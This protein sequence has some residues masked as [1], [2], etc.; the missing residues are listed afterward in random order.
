MNIENTNNKMQ[1]EFK[2]R[3]I[4]IT[5]FKKKHRQ[6][7][8]GKQTKKKNCEKVFGENFLC[9]FTV[10]HI[11]IQ[12]WIEWILGTFGSG[13]PEPELSRHRPKANSYCTSNCYD[14]NMEPE[15]KAPVID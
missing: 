8:T 9:I 14:A 13:V 10:L 7:N 12:A 1:I 6:S 11:I 5:E 3:L 15:S 4:L 2:I